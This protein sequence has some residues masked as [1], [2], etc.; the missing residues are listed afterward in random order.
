MRRR[1][2]AIG[3]E[4]EP[5]EERD[6][7]VDD[8]DLLVV[9]GAERMLAVKLRGPLLV[10]RA[11]VRA[12]RRRGGGSIVN[13]ASQLGKGGIGGYVTY[14]ATQ[15]GVVGLTEALAD[16]LSGSGVSAWAVCP[17]LT[18]TDMAPRAV[19]VTRGER[20]GLIQPLSVA[21][22]IVGLATGRRRAPSG[23][24]IDVLR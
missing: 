20:A 9:A 5:A 10:S 1:V 24:A 23:A 13:V 8:D 6:G 21:S 17:G 4:V 7:V 16:E 15:F 19:G 11:V 18:D 12:L 3:R 14:C 22:V 2:P